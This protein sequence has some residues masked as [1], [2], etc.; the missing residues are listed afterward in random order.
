MSPVLFDVDMTVSPF[1]RIALANCHK[2]IVIE[3]RTDQPFALASEIG[4]F[5]ARP[6]PW[7]LP[8]PFALP[9]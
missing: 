4:R 3:Q 5:L 8:L 2:V 1:Q 7:P 9:Q 6:R